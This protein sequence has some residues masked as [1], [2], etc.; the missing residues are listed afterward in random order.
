MAKRLFDLLVALGGIALLWP[1]LVVLAVVVKLTSAGP[2][3]FRQERVGRHGRVFRIH[4]FRTMI[5][6]GEGRGPKITVAGDARITAAGQVMRRCKLDELGQ[7]IDV[8]Q[9]TMSLVGP[10]PEVP[11][12]VELYPPD[13]RAIILSVKPGITDEAS[14]RYRDESSILAL[15]ADPRRAYIDDILPKKLESG[16]AYARSHSVIGDI[17]IILRTVVALFRS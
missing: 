8:V 7:L 1:L 10:R 2:V 5:A 15:A 9:G 12:Y 13:L 4:K 14:I 11:E 16:V 3:F 17:G 6:D